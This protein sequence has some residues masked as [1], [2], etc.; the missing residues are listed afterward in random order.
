MI[1]LRFC[2]E[3]GCTGTLRAVQTGG[4]HMDT[5]V[6]KLKCNKCGQLACS[7]QF[8]API[9][10]M[11]FVQAENSVGEKRSVLRL[12]HSITVELDPDLAPEIRINH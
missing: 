7:I 6:S 12:R 5:K 3:D 10:L 1:S 8:L 9:E 2:L 11:K 4:Y